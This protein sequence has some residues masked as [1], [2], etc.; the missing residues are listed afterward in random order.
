LIIAA[1]LLGAQQGGTKESLPSPEQR[2]FRA[3]EPDRWN[4]EG[5]RLFAEGRFVDAA[6]AFQKVYELF[7]NVPDVGY[8]LGL[9]YQRA[10][11]YKNPLGRFENRLRSSLA[12][13]EFN[14]PW[15]FPF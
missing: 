14:E 6:R 13:M 7:P 5:L 2:K 9:A 1:A 12:T 10:G 15:E 3:R 8:N 11:R 4:Q